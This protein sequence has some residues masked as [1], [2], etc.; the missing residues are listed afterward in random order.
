MLI[1]QQVLRRT[2]L[3]LLTAEI[4][5]DSQHRATCP[6]SGNTF[7]RSNRGHEGL[8]HSYSHHYMHRTQRRVGFH[9]QALPADLA[10]SIGA[11]PSS[12]TSSTAT[13]ILGLLSA[14]R[15]SLISTNIHFKFACGVLTVSSEAKVSSVRVY[16]LLSYA[17]SCGASVICEQS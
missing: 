2:L 17:G 8:L 9:T 1:R 4:Y 6:A 7:V 12:L 3:P 10:Q 5:P 14:L 11:H 16:V 15:W 13:I